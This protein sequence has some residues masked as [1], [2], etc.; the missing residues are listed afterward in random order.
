MKWPGKE[1]IADGP[2]PATP[3]VRRVRDE[4]YGGRAYANALARRGFVVLAHDVLAWGSRRVPL[5]AM[6]DPVSALADP[7]GPAPASAAD[8]YDIAA[9]QHEHVLAKYCTLL[10]TS[11]AG[12]VAGEDL[13]AAAYLRSRPDVADIGCVGL[14]GGGLR[15][16][17]LG[18]F[19]PAM[20]AVAIIAMASS[21][22]DML[23]RHVATHTWMLYPPG[24]TRLCDYPDLVAS[25]APAPLLVQYATEDALFPLSGMRRAHATITEHYRAT[26]SSYEGTFHE[27]PHSFTRNM[28]EEAFTWLTR[29]LPRPPSASH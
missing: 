16:A 1:K 27:V 22:R 14:S 19:D 17:L 7:A 26:P 11:F 6:P 28:Q 4:L 10:G 5:T 13:A 3:E 25:R 24:L 9:A 21:Y 29:H 2:D 23:D 15:A 8:R 12:V 18:A 20:R